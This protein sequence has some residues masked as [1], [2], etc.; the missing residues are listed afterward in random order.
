MHLEVKGLRLLFDGYLP[1]DSVSGESYMQLFS[2]AK[3]LIDYAFKVDK[4]GYLLVWQFDRYL[5]RVVDTDV[6]GF[7]PELWQFYP[8]ELL[9]SESDLAV[10]HYLES[11]GWQVKVTKVSLDRQEYIVLAIFDAQGAILEEAEAYSLKR[12][13]DSEAWPDLEQQPLRVGPELVAV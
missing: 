13:F 10:A 7:T 5:F 9:R 3:P 2:V 11:L 12:L 8:V 6:L 1:C 4:P